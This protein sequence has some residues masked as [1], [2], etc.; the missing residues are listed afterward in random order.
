MGVRRGVKGGRAHLSNISTRRGPTILCS[1]NRSFR[2]ERVISK[3]EGPHPLYLRT[4]KDSLVRSIVYT[5]LF[6]GRSPCRGLHSCR[7]VSQISERVRSYGDEEDFRRTVVL[8][9]LR[10][11]FSIT[12]SSPINSVAIRIGNSG[13]TIYVQRR[14]VFWG[15]VAL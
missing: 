2:S 11:G 13:P 12:S 6:Q 8:V 3:T 4:L 15:P 7:S 10:L 5:R 14:K 1:S 9:R